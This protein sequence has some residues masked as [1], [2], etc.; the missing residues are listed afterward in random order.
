MDMKAIHRLSV[1][2]VVDYYASWTICI[3]D[4]AYSLVT[5]VP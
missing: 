4:M 2:H 1:R 3:L 5:L